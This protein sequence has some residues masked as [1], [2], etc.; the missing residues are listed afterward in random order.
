MALFNQFKK[1]F[2]S[3]NDVANIN[4]ALKTHSSHVKEEDM[5]YTPDIL[6][7]IYKNV[8]FDPST[9]SANIKN[10]NNANPNSTNTINDKENQDKKESE[11]GLSNYGMDIALD[12]KP[13]N[14]NDVGNNS[15]SPLGGAGAEVLMQ[16]RNID[17]APSM[18]D[19]FQSTTHISD[20]KNSDKNGPPVVEDFQPK[21]L[22]DKVQAIRENGPPVFDQNN[23]DS[24]KEKRK[25]WIREF[26]DNEERIKKEALNK[27]PSKSLGRS[28]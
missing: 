20:N 11:G 22:L 6:A 5:V 14:P 24:I 16:K 18:D 1:L 3:N 8:G 12:T 4:T 13:T 23:T 10:T 27:A 2:F 19:F 25:Q 28:L 15:T 9:N 7:Q 21:T 17:K 26:L